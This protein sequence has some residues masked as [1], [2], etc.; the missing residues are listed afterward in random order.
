MADGFDKVFL[1][2]RRIEGV[3]L[4]IA[5]VSHF[6]NHT[7][8]LPVLD[9]DKTNLKSVFLSILEE[10]KKL[11]IFDSI[12]INMSDNITSDFDFRESEFLQT[13]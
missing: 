8:L 6:F 2:N 10:G 1:F 11:R 3:T 7:I 9:T 4:P 12:G 5:V 13:L